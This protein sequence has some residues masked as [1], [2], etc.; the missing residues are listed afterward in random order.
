MPARAVQPRPAELH[1]AAGRR[2]Q[3]VSRSTG[4]CLETAILRHL[5]GAPSLAGCAHRC[6][7]A[8]PP[9]AG[10]GRGAQLPRSRSCPGDHRLSARDKTRR[11]TRGATVSRALQCVPRLP[12]RESPSPTC[13]ATSR[14]LGP[15]MP[16]TQHSRRRL[17]ASHRRH[18]C[19]PHRK[20]VKCIRRQP[21]AD[22]RD[23]ETLDEEDRRFNQPGPRWGAR[24]SAACVR[25]NT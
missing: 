11:G 8:P 2:A 10:R 16:A 17:E 5:L 24:R 1:S 19:C 21:A 23:L 20:R 14:R 4:Q 9:Q 12:A 18:E 6:R 13:A 25:R 7:L 22:R 3:A 15:Q